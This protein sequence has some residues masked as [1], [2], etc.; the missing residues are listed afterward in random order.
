MRLGA[1]SE[2]QA[3]YSYRLSVLYKYGTVLV[4]RYSSSIILAP[5]S[6]ES[7]N[8]GALWAQTTPRFPDS[9]GLGKYSGE[10]GNIGTA[11]G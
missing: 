4:L 5:E 9:V 1:G 6:T 2:E 11:G 7:G 3:P 10:G 8:L